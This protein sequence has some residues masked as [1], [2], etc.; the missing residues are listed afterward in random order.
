ML[1]SFQSGYDIAVIHLENDLTFNKYVRPVEL[2]SSAAD[3]E[4]VGSNEHLYIAGWGSATVA[5][6]AQQNTLQELEVRHVMLN[7]VTL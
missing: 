1:S 3:S 2:A 7:V 4:K 6:E 5:R